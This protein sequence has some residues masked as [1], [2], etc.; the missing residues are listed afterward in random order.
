[1]EANLRKYRRGISTKGLSQNKPGAPTKVG[2]QKILDSGFRRNDVSYF[3]NRPKC[4]GYYV[5][6]PNG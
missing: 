2:V 5:T 4:M 6:S 1:M 3:G